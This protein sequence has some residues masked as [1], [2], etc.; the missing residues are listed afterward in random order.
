M[1]RPT[2]SRQLADRSLRHWSEPLPEALKRVARRCILDI[3]GAGLAGTVKPIAQHAAAF[4][5]ATYGAGRSTLFSGPTGVH[6]AGCAFANAV[7]AHALDYDDTCH[8][9]VV[10]ATA[11]VFPATF[12]AAQARAA[13]GSELL[14]GF[15]AGVETAYALGRRVGP[16]PYDRGWFAT[17]VIA[18]VGAAAGAA[19]IRTRDPAQLERAIVLAATQAAGPRVILGTDTKPWAAGVAALAGHQAAD[20][21]AWPIGVPGDLFG[22]DNGYL[23]LFAPAARANR[24]ADSLEGFGLLDPG[25]TFKRHPVCSS[26]QTTLDA[27]DSLLHDTDLRASAIERIDVT[28]AP[29]AHRSLPYR[30]PKN[31][32]QAQFSLPFIVACRLLGLDLLEAVLEERHLHGARTKELM[33]RVHKRDRTLDVDARSYPEAAHARIRLRDGSELEATRLTAHGDPRSPLSDAELREKFFRA[34]SRAI[35]SA[36]A[37]AIAERVETLETLPS[38]DTLSALIARG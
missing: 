36:S 34:A 26:A 23:Q 30:E 14:R 9:G 21:A 35:P 33:A 24:G 11:V 37:I 3:I 8:A 25:I 12:A 2:L 16:E 10:H 6:P 38:L 18:T 5:A 22:A 29:L 15:I 1:S 20:A 17:G 4:A 31:L 19:I 27:L 28:L 32:A 13:S 7:A